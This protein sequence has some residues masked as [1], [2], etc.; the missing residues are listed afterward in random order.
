[1]KKIQLLEITTIGKPELRDKDDNIIQ[2]KVDEDY[3]QM[4]LQVTADKDVPTG[5]NYVFVSEEDL[6]PR[7]TRSAWDITITESNRHG[8][9]LT[10]EQFESKYPNLVG[11]T[12]Q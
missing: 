11:Y 10:K 5:V 8:V 2:A 12:V 3:N 4:V 1:M 9:G 7:D 6:P